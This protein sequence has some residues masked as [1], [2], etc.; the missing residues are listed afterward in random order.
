M[1]FAVVASVLLGLVMTVGDWAWAAMQLPHRVAYGITH[2]AVMCLCVG[3]AVGIR[4]GRP[5]PG[6][7][8]GPVIGVI[9]AMTFYALWP[10]I[11]WSAMF[12]AFTGTAGEYRAYV[13]EQ[14]STGGDAVRIYEAQPRGTPPREI[15]E[16]ALARTDCLKAHMLLVSG[17][18]GHLVCEGDHVNPGSF[19]W[20]DFAAPSVLGSARIGVFPDGL[21][22]VPVAR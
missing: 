9:A 14:S 7:L 11:R 4:A 2:G 5:L 19:V 20:L 6:A 17:T 16:L 8:A 13:P 12:A 10:M 21:A 1:L 22:L 15:G 3:L 18:R